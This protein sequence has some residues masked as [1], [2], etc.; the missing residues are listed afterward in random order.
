M[1]EQTITVGKKSIGDQNSLKKFTLLILWVQK[2]TFVCCKSSWK[3]NENKT[4]KKFVMDNGTKDAS[5]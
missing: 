5:S 1:R 2:W 4:Q 3:I